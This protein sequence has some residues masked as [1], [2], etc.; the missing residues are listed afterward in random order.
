[1]VDKKIKVE[2]DITTKNNVSSGIGKGFGMVIGIFLALIVIAVSCSILISSNAKKIEEKSNEITANAIKEVYRAGEEAQQQIQ[3]TF[4]ESLPVDEK[5]KEKDEEFKFSSDSI[6][7]TQNG[8]SLSLDD[9]KY[10]LK[11]ENWGK[12]TEMTVTILNK[13]NNNFQPKVL[14]LLYDE[15]DP[16]EEWI[17]PKAEIEF[18]MWQLAVGEHVTKKA[19]TNVVFNDLDLPKK[20]QLVLVDAYDWDN[21]A[22]VVVEKEFIA[23]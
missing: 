17:T 9:F 22:M 13:G 7:N 19:I 20:L 23:K 5:A 12:I 1:M 10:E 8:I 18:D 4:D 21:R 14:V 3:K 6:I 16:K 2:A 15:K 11:K